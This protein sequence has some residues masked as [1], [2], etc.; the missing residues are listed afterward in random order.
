MK[1]FISA[2]MVFL[3]AANMFGL[4]AQTRR[5]VKAVKPVAAEQNTA[6]GLASE[7]TSPVLSEPWNRGELPAALAVKNGDADAAIAELAA[8]I[9]AGNAESTPA[10]LA[11]LQQAGFFIT[12]KDGSVMLA[13]DDGK[14]QGLVINGWEVASA[15]RMFGLKKTVTVGE[16]DSTLKTIPIFTQVNAA[17]LMMNGVRANA[18]NRDNKYLRAWARLIIELGKA[19]SETAG[20]IAEGNTAGDEKINAIQHLLLFRRLYGDISAVGLR[21]RMRAGAF[22]GVSENNERP[23]AQRFYGAMEHVVEPEE[24]VVADEK[25]IPCKMDGNA[26]TIMDASATIIGTGYGELMGYLTDAFEGTPTGTMLEKVG[27]AQAVANTVLVYAKFIQTYAALEVKLSLQGEPPLIRTKNAVPGERKNLKADVRMNIGN[28]QMYNC[29]RTAMNLTAG[30]DFATLNDGP[31]S[32]IGVTW[33][34][35]QGGAKDRYSNSTGLNPNGEQ[36]VGFTQDGPRI[37]DRGTIAGPGRNGT[38]VGNAR[39]T[40]TDGNGVANII[41]EGSPQ[42]NHKNYRARPVMK[43]AVVYT[44]IRMKAGEIKGDMVDVMGQALGGIPGLIS[45]PAELLY[46]VSWFAAGELNVPVRDWEDCDGG[47]T[48]SVTAVTRY[49]K[50]EPTRSSGNLTEAIQHKEWNEKWTLTVTGEQDRSGGFVNGFVAKG[51]ADFKQTNYARNFYAQSMCSDKGRGIVRGSKV[52]TFT[53]KDSATGEVRTTLYITAGKTSG[54]LTASFSEEIEG[55]TTYD[56]KYEG[57]CPLENFTNTKFE[58]SK[59]PYQHR[60][61]ALSIDVEIDPKNPDV[62]QGSKTVRNSDGSETTYTWNLTFCR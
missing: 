31:I 8:K 59:T 40:K 46:R 20:L 38:Q 1:E 44:T 4:S 5:A 28:W 50:D 42:K 18:E 24:A 14:G 33:S 9:L 62:L 51:S 12:N 43:N 37:Q 23:R 58:T 16:L 15:I 56:R 29:I 61:Q 54:S 36:I 6:Y 26:P 30:I 22:P 19:E 11:A 17:T 35:A 49:R 25:A 13:P 55:P 32:D 7:E 21:I 34:L 27:M 3:A 53:R 2:V 60:P 57:P 45:M 39:Y 52:E 41:L 48:G 10:L 47:W